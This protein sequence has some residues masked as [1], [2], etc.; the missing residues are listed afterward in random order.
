MSDFEYSAY[1]GLDVHTDSMAVAIARPGHRS[2]GRLCARTHRRSTVRTHHCTVTP[3]GTRELV[4][5][6]GA[7]VCEGAEVDHDRVGMP[8][9]GTET[10]R[11]RYA[12]QPLACDPRS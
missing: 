10:P 11:V 6:I 1:V 2:G 5:V 12:A 7:I 9:A 3:A 8:A 4:G